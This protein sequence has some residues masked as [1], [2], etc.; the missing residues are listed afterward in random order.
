MFPRGKGVYG[1]NEAFTRHK[2]SWLT[3][4]SPI[5]TL[6]S[7]TVSPKLDAHGRFFLVFRYFK[8]LLQ[9]TVLMRLDI[10]GLLKRG[11]CY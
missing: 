2:I 6:E 4:S 1:R 3:C 10:E 8:I 9:V 11:L 7:L 5:G